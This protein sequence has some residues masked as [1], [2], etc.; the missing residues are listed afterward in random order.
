MYLLLNEDKVIMFKSSTLAVQEGTGYHLIN[1]GTLA[2]PTEF[3]REVVE[4][5][6]I[7]S[8]VIEG[9]YQYING[10]FIQYTSAIDRIKQG[11]QDELMQELIDGG[12]I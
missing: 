8:N 12:V 2:V 7:P 6:S 11:A 10:E 3:I 4:V 5:E 9:A 1:N